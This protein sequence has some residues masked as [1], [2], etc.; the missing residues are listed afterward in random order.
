MVIGRRLRGERYSSG[1]ALPLALGG[2][3]L[4]GLTLTQCAGEEPAEI[5]DAPFTS[6]SACNAAGYPQGLCAAGYNGAVLEH[7]STAPRFTSLDACQ[8]DWGS[9]QCLPLSPGPALPNG[10]GLVAAAPAALFAPALAGFVVTSAMQR[11][12][13]EECERDEDCERNYRF[14]NYSPGRR[15]NEG[16]PLYR[17]RT[18][19]TVAM[20]LTRAGTRLRPVAVNSRTVA[21][22]GF[23]RSGGFRF[24]G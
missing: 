5:A 2:L 3:G 17:D 8:E 11:N 14:G 19:R 6:V 22:G 23:G 10:A 15:G 1:V 21:R 4:V 24:G 13:R 18:G 16:R 9:N 20:D 7:E 12:Y